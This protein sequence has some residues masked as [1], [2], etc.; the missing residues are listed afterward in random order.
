MEKVSSLTIVKWVK[1]HQDD[2]IGHHSSLQEKQLT[3]IQVQDTIE[4]ILEC[5]VRLKHPLHLRSHD[6]PLK[7][8]S[9]SYTLTEL[10]LP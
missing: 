6:R 5:K 9:S 10:P 8:N 4:I 2:K 3:S 7:S 1:Y